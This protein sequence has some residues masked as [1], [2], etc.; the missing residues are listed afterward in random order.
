MVITIIGVVEVEVLLSVLTRQEMEV[1]VAVVV[2][3]APLEQMEQAVDLQSTVVRTPD[4]RR[5]AEMPELIPAVEVAALL[6]LVPARAAMAD[7]V[8]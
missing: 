7:Q 3:Q 6:I 4:R 2:L 1:L 8:L 5:L